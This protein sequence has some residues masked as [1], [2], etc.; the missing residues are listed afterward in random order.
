MIGAPDV[1]VNGNDANAIVY[2]LYRLLVWERTT[3]SNPVID[4]ISQVCISQ[5]HFILALQRGSKHIFSKNPF[6]WACIRQLAF[7]PECVN[8]LAFR[9][10]CVNEFVFLLSVRM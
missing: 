3:G 9:P 2:T 4:F 6:S 10:E 8:D 7:R 5:R 1:D